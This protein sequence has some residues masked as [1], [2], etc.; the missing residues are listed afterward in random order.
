[1]TG[2]RPST[3]GWLRDLP[4]PRDF[5]PDNPVVQSLYRGLKPV[6]A[7]KSKRVDWSEFFLAVRDQLCLN[8]SSTHACAGL[9]EYF[10]RRSSGVATEA[11]RL[12]LY[13]S[14]RRLS[15]GAGACEADLRTTLKA[16]AR[17]GL[18]PERLWPYHPERVHDEPEPFLY[19]YSRDYQ[20]MIYVRLDGVGITGEEVL[21]N[22]RDH[23]AAG[24]PSA[25]GFS[26]FNS[27]SRDA[28]I[29]CPTKFD[30]VKGGGAAIAVGYDDTRRIRSTKGALRVRAPGRRLGR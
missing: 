14:A 24:F 9:A 22:I 18:P 12:F 27:L 28:D 16:L 6:P 23:L 15:R 20:S 25:F 11:S 13:Q 10:E 29:P 21:R 4:D 30:A 26:A 7:C 19:A 1:M 2:D 3:F 5:A 17:F 8:A